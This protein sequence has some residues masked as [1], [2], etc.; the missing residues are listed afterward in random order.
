M[1]NEKDQ[2]CFYYTSYSIFGNL[3]YNFFKNKLKETR[4]DRYEYKLNH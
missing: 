4:N 2:I 3:V 1:T